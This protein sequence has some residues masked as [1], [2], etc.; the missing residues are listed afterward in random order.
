MTE[1]Y[2]GDRIKELLE[3]LAKHER[4]F[5]EI[6]PEDLSNELRGKLI[7]A[8]AMIA[9]TKAKLTSLQEN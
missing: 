4:V 7:A 5:Y 2:K 1:Y 9:I 3:D 8:K 6:D